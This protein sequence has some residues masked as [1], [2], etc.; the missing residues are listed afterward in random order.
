MNTSSEKIVPAA[1]LVKFIRDRGPRCLIVARH[2]ET[3]WNRDG[4]LQGQQDTDLNERGRS[5]A[6]AVA[7]LL[8]R[9]EINQIHSSSLIRCK[10]TAEFIAA[11]N[12]GQPQI[13]QSDQLKETALGILEGELKDSQSTAELRQHYLAFSRDEI[14]YRI[15]GGET[16]HDVFSRVQRFFSEYKTDF[17]KNGLHLIVGHRNVN[18]MIL[19]HLLD[20]SFQDGFRIEQENQRLYLYFDETKELWSCFLKGE[21]VRLSQGYAKTND[22]SYA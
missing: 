18:K 14:N 12:I 10:K 15:P 1:N 20:L 21:T 3:Q 5:Q 13:I 9:L 7:H 19:K 6:L 16:L 2:G 11:S 4:K 8:A 22:S 17:T